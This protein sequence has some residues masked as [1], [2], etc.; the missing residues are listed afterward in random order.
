MLAEI[1]S[2]DIIVVIVVGAVLLLFGGSRLPK[3]ARSIG[4]AQSEFKKGIA[5]GSK[6]GSGETKPSDQTPPQASGN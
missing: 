6:N 5:D 3:L 4:E 2:P 1:F